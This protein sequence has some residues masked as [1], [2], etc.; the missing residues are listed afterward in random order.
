MDDD[1][2]NVLQPTWTTEEIHEQQRALAAR[3]GMSVD[4]AYA[5]MKRGEF[6][7][8]ILESRLRMLAFLLG[9]DG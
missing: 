6:H 3:V 4:E 8:T 2:P 9:E 7:G 5:A 1:I